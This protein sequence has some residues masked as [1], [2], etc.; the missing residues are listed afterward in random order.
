MGRGAIQAPHKKPTAWPIPAA[1]NGVVHVSTTSAPAPLLSVVVVTHNVEEL[2]AGCLRSVYASDTPFDF[3]VCV[4]DTGADGS[5]SMVR[6]AFPQVAVIE[7]PDNPGFAA[8]NN[9]GLR[10]AR[11]RYCLL[12]NPDTEVPSSA[13][14]ETVAAMEAEPALGILGP[15]LMRGNG[16]LDLACRRSFPTPRNALFHFLRLPR[17]FP[18]HPGFGEYNL[19][20]RDPDASY[21]VDAVSG[22]YM[23]LRRELLE[24]VGL[25][26]ESFWM[27]GED[28]DLCWRSRARGWRTRYNA[29]VQVL[30][31]KG[32]SSKRRSLQCTFE[33]FRAMHLFYQKHY[34]PHSP[35]AWNALV[36]IGIA[37][38]GA[39]SLALDRMRPP[40]RRRVS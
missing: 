2:L 32:Q 26:D 31:L 3:E 22:A 12:L 10:R 38:F 20:Y 15:K 19:T 39:G 35:A 23:L 24:Q 33:F 30:H 27:Y 40:A 9:L 28:L 25:L 37:A 36:T 29:D 6:R 17:L 5:A 13:L 18:R 34:A 11:G 14:A 21:D 16:T 7:A 4:V 1:V 8:A